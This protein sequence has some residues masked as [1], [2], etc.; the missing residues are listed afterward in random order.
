[1]HPDYR[2]RVLRGTAAE[3]VHTTLF[4]VKFPDA[5]HRVLRNSTFAAWEAAGRPPSGQRPGEG[6]V[7]GT[8]A[9]GNT[10]VRYQSVAARSDHVGDIEAFAIWAGQGVGLVNRVQPAGEIVREIAEDAKR[11]LGRLA[12]RSLT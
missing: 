2:E 10:A 9:Y 3:T 1:M 8:D 12:E 11:T 4:D 5:P 6:D 7:I